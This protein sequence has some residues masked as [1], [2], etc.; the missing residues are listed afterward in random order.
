[1]CRN[2]LMP[3][4]ATERR[5]R[6]AQNLDFQPYLLRRWDMLIMASPANL[7]M[8]ARRS[9]PFRGRR[10]YFH[11]LGPDQFFLFGLGGPTHSFTGQNVRNKYGVAVGMR[12]SIPA[13]NKL[14][15]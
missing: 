7:K 3:L 12:Q 1:M 5:K 15:N 2:L 10:G 14:L 6:L 13:I 9:Y 11:Q 8:W 4:N